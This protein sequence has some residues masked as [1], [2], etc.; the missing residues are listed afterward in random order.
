M[1]CFDLTRSLSTEAN[2]LSFSKL[3]NYL[4][5]WY[6]YLLEAASLHHNKNSK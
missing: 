6:K 3:S 2:H 4:L 1:L 5:L